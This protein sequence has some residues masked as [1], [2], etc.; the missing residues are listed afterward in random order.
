MI[1][2]IIDG[3]SL[4]ARAFFADQQDSIRVVKNSA[5]NVIDR[6][7]PDLLMWAWD[8]ENRKSEKRHGFKPSEYGVK[9]TEAMG[10]L[11][12]VYGGVSYVAQ[13]GEADDVIASAAV[14]EMRSGNSVVIATTDGDMDYLSVNGIR[15]YDIAKKAYRNKEDILLKWGVRKLCHIPLVKAMVGDGGDGIPGVS[16]VGKKTAA[17][18]YAEKC[19]DTQT[20]AEAKESIRSKFTGQ[21]LIDFDTALRA[22]MLY[23]TLS[24][25]A[26]VA[27]RR[28]GEEDDYADITV[29]SE[30]QTHR[31]GARTFGS[32]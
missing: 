6:V 32:R 12:N 14:Q 28:S 23:T 24:V 3:P 30:G 19:N 10:Y 22:V 21:D 29:R 17:S 2:L 31:S 9:S 4:F 11:K 13:E 15:V 5:R 25:P 1:S 26:A 8:G 16:R 27:L 18:I 7:N 20:F